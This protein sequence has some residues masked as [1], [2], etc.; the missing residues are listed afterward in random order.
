M[1]EHGSGGALTNPDKGLSGRQDRLPV[2]VHDRRTIEIWYCLPNRERFENRENWLPE[3]APNNKLDLL[4]LTFLKDDANKLPYALIDEFSFA[5][6]TVG[7]G[8]KHLKML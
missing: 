5:I 1:R 7:K 3:R 6:V 8:K 2:L 4:K